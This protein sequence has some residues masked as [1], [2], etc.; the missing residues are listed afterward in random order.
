MPFFHMGGVV[1]SYLLMDG[2]TGNVVRAG[3]VPVH[4]GFIK[5]NDLQDTLKQ[6]L[7]PAQ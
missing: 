2:K 6:E 7:T 5:A 3:V 4:G 1:A